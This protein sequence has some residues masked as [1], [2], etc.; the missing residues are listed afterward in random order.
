[1]QTAIHY[2]DLTNKALQN[3]QN[4]FTTL[5]FRTLANSVYDASNEGEFSVLIE[6]PTKYSSEI[7]GDLE[8]K[9]FNVEEKHTKACSRRGKYTRVTW[10][11][12]WRQK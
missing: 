2:N 1:M 7:R 8:L 9:G 5:F 12:S 10:T 11:I 3:K 4:E 6:K